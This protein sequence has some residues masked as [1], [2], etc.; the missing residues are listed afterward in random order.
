MELYIIF[1]LYRTV[2]QYLNV[3][4]Y[5]EKSTKYF[6]KRSRASFSQIVVRLSRIN[7]TLPLSES[8]KFVSIE[9]S[10]LLFRK[11]NYGRKR[12]LRRTQETFSGRRGVPDLNVLDYRK[13][14]QA[15]CEEKLRGHE[16]EV[17]KSSFLLSRVSIRCGRRAAE[18][19]E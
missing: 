13:M 11:D 19:Q 18:K 15:E 1:I 16:E 5:S 17:E 10:A 7:S 3:A 9:N 6:S 4:K 8:S 14:A 12:V 2:V